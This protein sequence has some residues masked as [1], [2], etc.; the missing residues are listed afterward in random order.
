M[1]AGSMR[2][3]VR[4]ERPLLGKD[5]HGAPE[6]LGWPLVAEVWA[7]VWD[8]SGAEADRMEQRQERRRTMVV[9]RFRR[10]IDATMRIVHGDRMLQI[11]GIAERERRQKLE[12]TCEDF[13]AEV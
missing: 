2:D 13:N 11:I 7:E 10:G 8:H 5:E 3:R 9:I 12:F 4:I 1:Y 6:V